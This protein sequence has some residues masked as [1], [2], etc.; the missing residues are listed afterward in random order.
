M[1]HGIHPCS[2]CQPGRQPF[3]HFRIKDSHIGED[4]VIPEEQ[5]PSFLMILDHRYIS[6]LASCPSGR[7]D[8]DV[9]C[10]G[11][12]EDLKPCIILKF[13]SF[14]QDDC[15]SLC[16]IDSTST[17]YANNAIGPQFFAELRP[18]VD[19]VDARVRFYICE[20][21]YAQIAKNLFYPFWDICI[22]GKLSIGNDEGLLAFEVLHFN[23]HIESSI[24]TKDYLGRGPENKIEID[25][26]GHD[27]I[28][29]NSNK[30]KPCSVLI[31]PVR[32]NAPLLPP[33]LR[34]SGPEAAAGL[35]FR[36]S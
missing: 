29:L 8:D 11:S 28:L 22:F 2:C 32:N 34:P 17:P 23:S 3:C 7:R 24:F 26:I 4:I 12:C 33:G 16:C 36:I 19:N 31:Y 5:L 18:L 14:L 10:L 25:I 20:N 15:D 35:D 6:D 1:T 21:S 9:R 27:S 30:K 13:S